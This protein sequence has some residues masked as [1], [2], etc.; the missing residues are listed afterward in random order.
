MTPL[1]RMAASPSHA[2]SCVGQR[3]PG[4]APGSRADYT[5]M[6]VSGKTNAIARRWLKLVGS[7]RC[8][9]SSAVACCLEMEAGVPTLGD[10]GRRR[11]SA[12]R[13]YAG[14]RR[15]GKRRTAWRAL[16]PQAVSLG[17][18]PTVMELVPR[19]DP[20]KRPYADGISVRGASAE[21][22]LPVHSPEQSERGGPHGLVLLHQLRE[23][24]RVEAARRN[25]GVLVESGERRGVG[26]AEAKGPIREHPFRVGEVTHDLLDAPLARRVPMERPGLVERL[27][28]P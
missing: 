5:V 19:E 17:Q 16:L 24:S 18:D 4:A 9:R 25:V 3:W 26:S 10:G 20:R 7:V 12:P 22:R 1:L 2:S 21:Q 8:A 11:G 27:E 13:L 28:E 6:E 23:R 15:A 14:G